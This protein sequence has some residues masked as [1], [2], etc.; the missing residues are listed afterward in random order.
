MEQLT[1]EWSRAVSDA[2]MWICRSSG[3]RYLDER[4]DDY[5]G[6]V[7]RS[8]GVADAEGILEHAQKRLLR[9]ESK[10]VRMLV[11]S[12]ARQ[13]LSGNSQPAFHYT[14]S[15]KVL[16]SRL[17]K[18]ARLHSGEMS[19]KD[20]SRKIRGKEVDELS[21]EDRLDEPYYADDNSTHGGN[22]EDQDNESGRKNPA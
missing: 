6:A 22:G 9:Y 18:I 3:D 1:D 16:R 14:L 10:I 2:M 5:L 4:I 12:V 21:A 11:E 19:L 15:A 8:H 7:S 13:I 20:P 17:L